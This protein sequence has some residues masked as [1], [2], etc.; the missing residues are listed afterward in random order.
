MKI[1]AKGKDH[2]FDGDVTFEFKNSRREIYQLS[3]QLELEAY[4]EA[5]NHKDMIRIHN[6]MGEKTPKKLS[7]TIIKKCKGFLKERLEEEFDVTINKI[8]IK[9][10]I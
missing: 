6:K 8:R 10:E 7:E 4:R 3:L 5:G 2:H 1:I 9:N